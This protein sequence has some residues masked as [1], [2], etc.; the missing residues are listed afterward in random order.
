M[1]STIP[2]GDP[3]DARLPWIR[4]LHALDAAW[5]ESVA[6][7]RLR[8]LQTA[9]RRL[10]DALRSG[11][12]VVAARSFDT[13][14]APYPV[15]FAFNGATLTTP[16]GLLLMK[17]RSILVQVKADGAVR[18]IL[19]NPT[20]PLGSAKAPFFDKLAA[21]SPAFLRKRYGAKPTPIL[22]DLARVGLRGEDIDVIAFDHFHV[23]DLR[24]TLGTAG[25]PGRFP[26]AL[27]L[28]PRV[29]WADWDDVHP[30]QAPFYVKEGKRG[31]D[32]A[33]VVLTDSDLWLGEGALLLRTPGHSSGNQTLFLHTESGVW[34]TCEN[35]TSADSWAPT[36]SRIPGLKRAATFFEQDVILNTNTPEFAGQQYT[37]MMLERSLVDRVQA[38]PEFF[39]MLPSSE[40]TWS[41]LAP[42]VRPSMVFGGLRSGQVQP[43]AA[44]AGVAA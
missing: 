17:N 6:G 35:G 41:W 36:A 34:G 43:R 1:N 19:F 38:C 24:A 11:P 21:E 18:N 13:S 31:I 8:A 10:G 4:K 39:Q 16:R 2:L 3:V 30:L 44:V 28:A 40:V 26:R 42:H 27:L 37:S 5:G 7:A 25:I 12:R 15:R 32:P 22:D 9:G 23:Q 33:R 14:F 29:E 20:D